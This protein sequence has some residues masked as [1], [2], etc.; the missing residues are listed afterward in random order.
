MDEYKKLRKRR[1]R[2]LG[3]LYT[4]QIFKTAFLYQGVVFKSDWYD[5]T[6]SEKWER[7]IVQISREIKDLEKK[8]DV[9]T[10]DLGME[11]RIVHKL[12]LTDLS[13][14]RSERREY[15]TKIKTYRK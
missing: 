11:A 2:K 12:Y 5:L 8:T 3:K 14:L 9:S 13:R 1:L 4:M 10:S 15:I 6:R 7:K